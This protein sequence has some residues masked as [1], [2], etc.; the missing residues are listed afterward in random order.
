MPFNQ[1]VLVDLRGYLTHNQ[2]PRRNLH[3]RHMCQRNNQRVI[4]HLHG[5]K[6]INGVIH[7]YML[8]VGGREFQYS[9]DRQGRVSFSNLLN[10][11]ITDARSYL[12]RRR[13]IIMNRVHQ[14]FY[15]NFRPRYTRG[16]AYLKRGYGITSTGVHLVAYGICSQNFVSTLARWEIG[17]FTGGGYNNNWQRLAQG[18]A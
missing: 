2:N 16:R 4:E 12:R 10:I 17:F 13:N 6:L 8:L 5:M 3:T 15:N 1:A 11:T 14:G 18:F 9:I 7:G